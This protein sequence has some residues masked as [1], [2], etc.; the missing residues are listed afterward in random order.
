MAII[1]AP[2][3]MPITNDRRSMRFSSSVRECFSL[4]IPDILLNEILLFEGCSNST[5]DILQHFQ[6]FRRVGFTSGNQHLESISRISNDVE[7][8]MPVRT[9]NHH[10][11]VVTPLLLLKGMQCPLQHHTERLT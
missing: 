2:M 4:M 8:D 9:G 1:N 6:A 3:H 7:Q 11:F 5:F 10:A